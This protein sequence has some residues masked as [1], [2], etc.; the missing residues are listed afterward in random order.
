MPNKIASSYL[1]SR[2]VDNISKQ[3]ALRRQYEA[4]LPQINLRLGELEKAAKLLGK[5]NVRE[6]ML[7][8]ISI[9]MDSISAEQKER[10][11]SFAH[12]MNAIEGVPVSEQTEQDIADWKQGK[13]SFISI[14]EA[15]LK[16][17]GFSGRE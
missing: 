9:G 2:D 16:R 14:F 6:L 8:K 11:I 10:S 1:K 15:T 7:L 12:C 17:Y 3:I 13:K 5:K 4:E